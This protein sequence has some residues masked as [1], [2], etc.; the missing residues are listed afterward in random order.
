M[1]DFQR[2]LLARLPLGESVL[3]LFA[4]V[5]APPFLQELFEKHRGRCY[6]RELTFDALVY[7]I[8]DALLVHGGSAQ[9]S[10]EHAQE[11]GQLPVAICNAYGKLGRLPLEL[12]MAFLSEGSD[13]L[14]RVMPAALTTAVEL[15]AS[16]AGMHPV[17]VDGK[18]L[19][20]AAKR[21]KVLRDLPGKLLGGKLLVALS[22]KSGLA[23]A[24]NADP[25][26]ERNDI[27]LVPGLLPQVRQRISEVILWIADR[28]FADLDQP[29]RFI[30]Q[31][32]HFLLRCGKSPKFQAD[33][34]RPMREG[35][36]ASG[37]LWRQQWG[38]IGNP[39]DKR[40]RYVRRITLYRPGEEDVVLI[41]D[42]LDAEKYPAVDLLA[43]Y[44]RRWGIEQMFQQ[45]TEVF[46]LQQLIGSR[47]AAMIFQGAFC[48][49]LYNMIQLIRSY[50]AQLSEHQCETISTEKLFTDVTHELI[51]WAKVGDAR[52]TGKGLSQTMSAAQLRVWL[53]AT[54]VDVWTDRWIKA[55][56][57]KYRP[58]TKV[59][60]P[61]GH[62]GHTSVWKVLQRAKAP[63]PPQQASGRS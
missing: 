61:T 4:Y 7:L 52:G 45:V 47:P 63:D 24:M 28:Q 53:G 1:D 15:P 16:L 46:S 13:R 6:E 42:L 10:F 14:G 5:L 17:V 19:K 44:L 11:S 22:L 49:L 32:D 20:K 3:R 58:K 34:G 33:P 54:L 8:R 38:W 9:Q 12:S 43:L 2:E 21:L 39:K 26:G 62:G 50:V 56:P 35:T 36:D 23:V 18:K 37:R 30:G 29:Q 41:T 48:L 31:Q 27:P 25:D 60:V 51:A 55:K 40:R 59:K 57:K